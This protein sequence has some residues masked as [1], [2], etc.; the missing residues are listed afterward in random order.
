MANLADSSDEEIEKQLRLGED[1]HW[2][3][4][5]IKFSGNKPKEPS[6]ND[7]SNELA[8]F[9]NAS[10]GVLLLGITD[11]GTI[12]DMNRAQLDATEIILTQACTDSIKPYIAPTILRKELDN[13]AFLLVAVP[14]GESLHKSAGGYYQRVGSKKQP[15]NS[16]EQLRLAQK[17]GQSR[18]IGFDK[19]TMA[20]TGLATLDEALW[21]PLLKARSTSQP[22]QAL[23]KLNLLSEDNNNTLR[24]TVAGLLLC[25]AN[26]EDWLPQAEITA[27]HYRGTNRAS[28]Q[29]DT[30]TITGPI[31][32]QVDQALKFVK[33]NMR[34][35]SRKAP[36]RVDMPQYS[37]Q[38][39]FEALVNAVAHRDYSIRQSRIRLSMFADRLEIASPGNLP[40]TLSVDSMAERQATRNEV[41][42]SV[43][44]RIP[45]PDSLDSA[46][47]EYFLER[48][49][50]GVPIIYETTHELSGQQATYKLITDS[51]LLLII[52]AAKLKVDPGE[53][54][55]VIKC[56]QQPLC[57]VDVLVLFPNK[58]YKQSKTNADGI[59]Y[60]E[61]HTTHLPMTVFASSNGYSAG[62]NN[63]WIPASGP[64]TLELSPLPNGGSA[65]FTNGTGHLPVVSGRLNPILDNLNRSYL[66]ADNI[67]INQGLQQ[68][69]NFGFNEDL[70]L[71]DANGREAVVRIIDII[72]RSALLQYQAVGKF[73]AS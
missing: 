38:A 42:A 59:A 5:E 45:V 12:Q 48:R 37:L 31:N 58:T 35:A 66:Y 33:R 64:L 50:D 67:A 27:T 9:A 54:A 55:V 13:K 20:D 63:D 39:V 62:H 4:K 26:P 40:N 19:Q 72:G 43:L 36:G 21:K 68:P 47:R 3:F 11:A 61:L 34:V 1:S 71:T 23:Q 24:A 25:C 65:L 44:G 51:E 70:H 18:F 32:Q 2:E 6:Q 29:L 41:L 30:Q 8:A 60:L 15:M 49:G 56:E 7:L 14:E 46:N 73:S 57:D 17:R 52:P 53:V 22:E 28:A 10:G 69:V 16:D